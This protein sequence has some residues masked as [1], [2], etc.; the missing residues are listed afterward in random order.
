MDQD[1]LSYAQHRF[2]E[3]YKAYTGRGTFEYPRA[4]I[5]ETDQANAARGIAGSSTVFIGLPNDAK[6]VFE[7]GTK[8]RLQITKATDFL[9]LPI[10]SGQE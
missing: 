9:K 7:N 8:Q 5:G 1:E 6:M 10:N 4:L 2:C 3:A